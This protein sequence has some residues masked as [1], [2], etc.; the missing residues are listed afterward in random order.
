MNKLKGQ[1]SYLIGNMDGISFEKATS[2][3]K[4]IS[5]FLK[6]MNVLV[7]DPTDKPNDSFIEDQEFRKKRKEALEQEDYNTVVSMM[8]PTRSIDLRC[9][10][11]SDFLVCNIDIEG[12]PFGSIEEIVTAN[13]QKKPI[14]IH[15]PQG[16]KALPP[17]AFAMC[18]HELFFDTWDDVQTYLFAVNS[19]MDSRTFDRWYFWDWDKLSQG[20]SL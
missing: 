11:K 19:G 6:S 3:R 5:K 8:K 17:W 12:K 4:D 14:I 15:C 20:T 10:D 9:V 13:R 7:L 2:W 18:P 16:K 1:F